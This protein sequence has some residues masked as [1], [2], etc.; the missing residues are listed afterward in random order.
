MTYN[1][2]RLTLEEK[3]PKTKWTFWRTKKILV[4]A[5]NWAASRS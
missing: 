4:P 2:M 5:G 3:A 1:F